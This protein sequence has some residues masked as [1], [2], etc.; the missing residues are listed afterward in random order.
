MQDNLLPVCGFLAVL[1]FVGFLCEI[2][3]ETIN[4]MS[5]RAGHRKLN[6]LNGY[7][8]IVFKLTRFHFFPIIMPNLVHYSKAFGFF[9]FESQKLKFSAK[10][11][12][13]SNFNVKTQID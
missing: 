11:S 5:R 2:W 6:I 3:I 8:L 4:N 12:H 13:F 7:F 9:Q 10:F 1:E